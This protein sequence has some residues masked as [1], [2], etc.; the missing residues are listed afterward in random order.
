M[1]FRQEYIPGGSGILAFIL[2]LLLQGWYV[3]KIPSKLKCDS[4]EKEKVERPKDRKKKGEN[5]RKKKEQEA[6]WRRLKKFREIWRKVLKKVLQ[7]PKWSLETCRARTSY[8]ENVYRGT[9]DGV[10]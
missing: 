4:K 2:V 6:N 5:W 7:G 8:L 1:L 9:V 3:L 10:G